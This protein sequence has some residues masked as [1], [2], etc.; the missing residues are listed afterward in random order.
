MIKFVRTNSRNYLKFSEKSETSSIYYTPI[1]RSTSSVPNRRWE[2][3]LIIE[4]IKTSFN[5]IPH[6][7]YRQ[8]KETFN[9]SYLEDYIDPTPSEIG[10]Q[11]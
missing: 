2:K 5:Q 11:F 4:G 10:F 9:E 6:G 3:E 1:R 7:I 8:D